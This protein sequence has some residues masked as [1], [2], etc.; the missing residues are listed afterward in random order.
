MRAHT[1]THTHAHFHL[2]HTHTHARAPPRL[3]LPRSCSCSVQ[4]ELMKAQGHLDKT[5]NRR[6]DE[7]VHYV[8]ASAKMRNLLKGSAKQSA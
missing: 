1:C 3:A 8:E 5:F 6:R 4:I 7:F 2:P